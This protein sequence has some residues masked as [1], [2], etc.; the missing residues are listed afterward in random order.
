D[1]A[2]K[3][4]NPACL[5]ADGFTGQMMEPVDV[6]EA[7]TVP[8]DHT[9]WCV[10]G[11]PETHRNLISSIFLEPEVLEAHNLK[12]DAK[13]KEIER[14]EVRFEEYRTEDADLIIVAYGI[15]S[16]IVYST[17]D[18]ART[19]GKKVGLLRP[20]TLWPYPSEILAKHAERD[21]QFLSVELSTGQMVEDVKLAVEGR[22]PVHFYGRCG[23]M[24]PGAGELL[25]EYDRILEGGRS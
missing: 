10:R 17:V 16:R 22:A 18:Q 6:P 21:V 15:L 3:Y 23:G 2:D 1:L 8:F 9:D 20:I 19:A 4:R 7:R 13:Y 14:N 5:M 12:L 24:V 11:T 25:A